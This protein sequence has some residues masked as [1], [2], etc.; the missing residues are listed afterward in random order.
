[1]EKDGRLKALSRHEGQTIGL[2]QGM[3]S[4]EDH[5]KEHPYNCRL[6]AAAPDL[7]EACE[8]V[9]EL[10][11]AGQLV[12]DISKDHEPNYIL[13]MVKFVPKLAKI[14]SAISK[15]KGELT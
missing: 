11:D 8:I 3:A 15:A 6:I 14:T 4:K 10:L 5:I 2:F 1:M 7:F 9:I 13:E 12:R